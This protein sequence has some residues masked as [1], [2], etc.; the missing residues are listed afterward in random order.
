MCLLLVGQS[1]GRHTAGLR[2]LFLNI[3]FT[4]RS[5]TMF[6]FISNI[7]HSI[8]EKINL[9]FNLLIRHIQKKKKKNISLINIPKRYSQIWNQYAVIDYSIPKQIINVY[10]ILTKFLLFTVSIVFNENLPNCFLPLTILI[11]KWYTGPKTVHQNSVLYLVNCWNKTYN[12]YVVS[13]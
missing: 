1:Y 7:D 2:I 12:I 5:W 10:I 3:S 4:I 13:F 6:V 9:N 8:C 11:S